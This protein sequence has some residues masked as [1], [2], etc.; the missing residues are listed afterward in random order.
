MKVSHT[1]CMAPIR[2]ITDL[3]YRNCFADLFKG[4][5]F[6]IAPFI[7]TV[8]GNQAKPSHLLENTPAENRLTT[9]PQ[10]I[11][12]NPD[13]FVDLAGQLA[14]VG[15]TAVN[16]N[17]GCPYPTM[18]KKK[19]G[20][21]LLPYPEQI[22]RFLDHVCSNLSMILSVKM[23][24]G[25][26]HP[27]EIA[28]ILPILNR[29]PLEHVTIHAR[30]G[31]QMYT[32]TV[33]LD[34]F[35]LC[36]DGLD[37]PVIYN[38]D[39]TTLEQQRMLQRRFPNVTTWMLGRGL[40]ANPCLAEEIHQGAPTPLVD[41]TRRIRTLHTALLDAYTRR[42]SGATHQIQKLASHWKYLHTGLPFG[43]KLYDKARKAHT[44]A[45]YQTIIGRAFGSGA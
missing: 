23:R 43:V 29:Y 32:G 10:I 20:S 41:K 4:V 19:C 3:V 26:Q 15:H 2:G 30:L 28:Q 24:L 13:H 38:G 44:M 35:G 21:G 8:K 6:A 40:L 14:D 33:D 1:Y 34:A 9:I 27:E 5:D 11:G 12:R 22:D 39:I 16:W 17:L 25:L 42:L 45:E 7:Q 18:T 37:H 31:I 36:L